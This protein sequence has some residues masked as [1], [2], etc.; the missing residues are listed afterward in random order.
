VKFRQLGSWAVIIA[1]SL[2]AWAGERSG[3]I[4]G[5]VRD[6]SGTPQ[7][8]AVVEIASAALARTLTLFTDPAGFYAAPDLF[9]G[10]VSKIG[11][12]HV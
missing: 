5:Y 8:G 10:G 1:M 3:G 12:A 7:M 2:P 9:P 6:A 4:S 11:R